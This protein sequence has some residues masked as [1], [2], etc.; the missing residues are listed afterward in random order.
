[1]HVDVD[2]I[3]E[4]S[5]PGWEFLRT[6][7]IEFDAVLWTST[8]DLARKISD[9]LQL[10]VLFRLRHR[11]IP[12]IGFH[13][14]RWWGLERWRTVLTAPFFR[15]EYVFTADG[16]H[17]GEFE[18]AGVNHH[19]SPPAIALR[20]VQWLE[21]KSEYAS[22]IAFV[23]SYGPGY[24]A[25]WPHR[26]KLARWLSDTYGSRVKFWPAPGG[27]AIRGDNLAHL[28][29]STKVVVGDSCLAPTA[30]GKPMSHYCSDRV[31]ETIGR[32]GL[33]VHPHVEGVTDGSLLK[34]GR[35][36]LTWEAGNWD[37][38]KRT[39]D[40]ALDDRDSRRAIAEQG[41]ER[42]AQHHTYAN[43]LEDIFDLLLLTG[44]F[45]RPEVA[46]APR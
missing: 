8:R 27:E 14:D 42:V 39:I 32:G 17:Q 25:E 45:T 36:L 34:H 46:L 2:R 44:D 41:Y 16:A 13:L 18:A 26:R 15:C 6:A 33:L 21:P 38:L 40:E 29:A 28:Y 30:T 31:F 3:Q 35:D 20:N 9:E 24:H 23:G 1:M 37:E 11:G 43:R 19:W 4:D 22:D 7:A 12:T 10:E 5:V